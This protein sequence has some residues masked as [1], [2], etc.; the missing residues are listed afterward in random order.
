MSNAV[1]DAIDA[2]FDAARPN[3]LRAFLIACAVG[4]AAAV[5]TY[6]FM[7]SR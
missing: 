2:R 7:R 6:R 3:P 1:A 4:F 5:V